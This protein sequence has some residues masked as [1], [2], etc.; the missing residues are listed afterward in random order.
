[1]VLIRSVHNSSGGGIEID[2]NPVKN[3]KVSRVN[4][5]IN[6]KLV[7]HARDVDSRYPCDPLDLRAEPR[8]R[9]RF[10]PQKRL[11]RFVP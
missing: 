4:R 10:Y 11:L 9:L 6:L 5:D 1:M 8:Q 3:G 7:T 2:V